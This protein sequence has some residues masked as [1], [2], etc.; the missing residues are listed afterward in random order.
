MVGALFVALPAVYFYLS[1]F[2][3]D[4]LRGVE[5]GEGLNEAHKTSATGSRTP[6]S[7]LEKGKRHE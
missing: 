7:E 2:N 3:A 4:G 1:D 6:T 5:E